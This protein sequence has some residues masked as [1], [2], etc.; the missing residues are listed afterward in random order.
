MRPNHLQI[1]GADQFAYGV[2][3]LLG[4]EESF[5]TPGVAISP[6]LAHNVDQVYF[7]RD[8]LSPAYVQRNNFV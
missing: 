3:T 6:S 5:L 2:E 4:H 7:N 8:R 1:R